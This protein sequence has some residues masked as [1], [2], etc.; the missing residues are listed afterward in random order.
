[1]RFLPVFLDLRGRHALVLGSGEVAERKA[2]ALHR[3]GAIVRI[4]AAFRP[5]MLDG[6]VVA[7][8]A[9]AAEPDLVALSQAA[10]ARGIPVNVVDNP[11]LCS[12]ITPSVI[13]RDP[14]V[15]AVSTGGAAPVLARM[16]RARIE[17]MLP[18][19][20]GRLAQLADSLKTEIRA[21]FPDVIQRRRMLERALGGTV[22]RLVFAGDDAA[23]R[24]AFLGEIAGRPDTAGMV[25][26]VNAGPGPPDMITLRAH[27][28][29]GEADVLVHD[30]DLPGPVLDMARRDAERMIYI[31]PAHLIQL[32][33]E[34][35]KIV[36]L[37]PGSHEADALQAAGIRTE[38][39]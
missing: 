24:Q 30:A 15:V 18:P 8:G 3:A 28:I 11:P 23:A 29:M 20:W 1:M 5:D 35:R 32:A 14:L 37:G 13:D 34:G 16:V 27:R 6:C 7:I 19:A 38:A 26:L 12:F 21:A 4:E 17:G 31:D 22:A 39:V 9:D 10:Q 36:R 25:Y 33:R 2:D